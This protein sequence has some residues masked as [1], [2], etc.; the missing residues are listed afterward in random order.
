M[1]EE[2]VSRR[3][4]IAVAGAAAAAAVIGGAAYYLTRPAPPAPTPTPTPKPTPAPTPKPTATPAPTPKPT[5]TSAPVTLT[6]WGW[7]YGVDTVTENLKEFERQYPGIKVDYYHISGGKYHDKIVSL[8]A[9]GTPIDVIYVRDPYKLEFIEAGWIVPLDTVATK[10]ELEAYKKDLAPGALEIMSYK[11]KLYGLPYYTGWYIMAYNE[12]I[13]KKAGFEH[14][15]ETWDEYIEQCVTIK[16][17][18]ILKYPVAHCWTA[19]YF[20]IRH[21]QIRTTSMGGKFF[22]EEW[23]PIFKDDPAALEALQMMQD[24]LVKYKICDPAALTYEDEDERDMLGSGRSAIIP[25]LINYDLKFLKDPTKS[26][27]ADKIKNALIPGGKPGQSGSLTYCRFY[28][29]PSTSKHKKEAWLLVQYLGGK[30]KYGEYRTAKL[31]CLKH[32]LSF[33]WLSLWEDPEIKESW[34]KWIPNWDA[35]VGQLDTAIPFPDAFVPWSTEWERFA[36]EQLQ[37][38]VLGELE[39]EKTIKSLADKWNELKAKY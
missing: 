34:S 12:E 9:A 37:K 24:E 5:P 19:R 39:A 7:S 27:A 4:Y 17:K 30:D 3:K 22:D 29:I 26:K 28:A 16:E 21:W 11:G 1:S 2:R 8:L 38:T 15:P 14:P 32:G 31:W 23:N 18:G 35:F 25:W 36:I 10:E 33:A 13:L 20:I 6:L